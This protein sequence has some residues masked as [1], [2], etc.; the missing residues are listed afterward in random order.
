MRPI[1]PLGLTLT[2]ALSLCGCGN[3]WW[4]PPF[5]GGYNPNLP[6]N[7]SDNMR[8]VMGQDAPTATLES[9]PGDIWPGPLP[10]SPTLRDIDTQSNIGSAGQQPDYPNS[11]GRG[12]AALPAPYPARGSSSPPPPVSA[13]QPAVPTRP[14]THA[15]VPP[16]P[17]DA[18]GQIIQTTRGPQV[19][20]GGNAG[21][22]TTTTPGGGSAI[23][24][25]NGNGTSTVIHGDGRVE[26]VPTPK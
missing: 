13:D 7:D 14:L 16:P 10:P 4:N 1:A 18:A 25:P 9:E 17:R 19:I 26:T 6:V 22:Q 11:G 15:V 5:T 23:V 20:T 12:S 21:Y 8:R 24:V 2:L 3:T